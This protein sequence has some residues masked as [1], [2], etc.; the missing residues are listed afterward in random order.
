MGKLLITGGAGF[1]GSA[2]ARNALERGWNIRIVDNAPIAHLDSAEHL[3]SAS[4]EIIMGDLR[5]QELMRNAVSGCDA[6][7]HLAAQVSVAASIVNPE[8]TMDINV[9]GTFQLIELCHEFGVER[10]IIAS[11]AAVYGN[12]QNLPLKEDDAGQTLSP[13]AHSKWINERQII[14]ARKKGLNAAALR[15]FNVYGIGQNPGGSYAAVIPKFIEQMVK[16]ISPQING[17][18]L[19]TRDFVH[20]NDVADA[21]LTLLEND[22]KAQ[23]YHAFNV[24]TQKETSLT[25]LV[26]MINKAIQKF[27]PEHQL[28]VPKYGPEREGDIRHSLA[29][30]ELIQTTLGWSPT[31]IFQ[32]GIEEMVRKKISRP[33]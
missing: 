9:K 20:V 14:E 7:V 22:W 1:I 12:A 8:E 3:K 10:V 32:D 23:K 16:G 21:I 33:K 28:I 25:D 15:F 30:I 31:I 5:N 13:Y 18:G 17:D 19:Q 4:V 11:S 26:N 24:A 6:V 2:L 29:N 27:Q